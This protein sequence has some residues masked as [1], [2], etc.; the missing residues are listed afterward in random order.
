MLQRPMGMRAQMTARRM[1]G[2]A[3]AVAAAGLT[4]LAAAACGSAAGTGTVSPPAAKISLDLTVTS[5]PG[6]T[7]R[8]WTLRCDPPGGTHPDPATACQ[9]L[10][11]VKDPFTPVPVHMDCPMIMV[12]SK[13]ATITG[14]YLG[15]PVN[16]TL[17]DGGCTLGRWVKL[18]KIFN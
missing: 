5:H 6:A 1:S 15:K 10:L 14:T 13:T 18:G 8:H 9:V 3:A 4:A 11:A 2:R 17:R 16:I 7:P 12:S